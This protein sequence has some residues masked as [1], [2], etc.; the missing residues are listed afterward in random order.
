MAQEVTPVEPPWI[1]S[2]FW[3]TVS[4]AALTFI[5][6]LVSVGIIGSADQENVSKAVSGAVGAI[7][8]LAANAFVVFQYIRS[9]TEQRVEIAKTE[10]VVAESKARKVE[11]IAAMPTELAMRME[12]RIKA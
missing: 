2:R 5:A 4:T 11:A 7:G 8:A 3:V 10:A 1:S 12:S 9:R 6:F